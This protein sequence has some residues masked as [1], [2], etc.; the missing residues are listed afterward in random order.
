VL[1]TDVHSLLHVTVSDDLVYDHTYSSGSH[2][3]D[4]SRSAMVEAMGHALLLSGIGFNIYDIANT[5]GNEE[6]RQL[7]WTM[8]F[9]ATLEHVARSRSVTE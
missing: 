3:V 9:K 1:N 6:G 2:I 5:V 7:H 8:F 4:D